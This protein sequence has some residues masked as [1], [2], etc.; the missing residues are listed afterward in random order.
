MARSGASLQTFFTTRADRE[1]LARLDAEAV[2]HHVAI[3]MDGNGRWA[4]KRG[5]PRIFGHRAGAK[6]I[7]ES[8]ATCIE[9]SIPY[10]TIYSFSSEN[11]RRSEDEVSGLM[12]LFIE[13]LEGEID[14]LMAQGVRVRVIGS[15]EGM[16][17]ATMAAFRRTEDRTAGNR[18]L[19]LLVALNYGGRMEIT[20]AVRSIAQEVRAGSLAPEA[21]TEDTVSD[22]LY[23]EGIPDPD[24]VIRTSGEMRISN[25]LLWQLAYAELWVTAVLWPD[26][27]RGDLLRAVVDYQKRARRFGGR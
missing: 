20:E 25:F 21:I 1:Q 13:V 22:H 4:A 2:P 3:I 10:L 5:V 7:R 14:N 19:T 6:A 23:T 15:E 18:R 11:W 9:L 26:F 16:P 8:I 27:K 17:A 24:L 12:G